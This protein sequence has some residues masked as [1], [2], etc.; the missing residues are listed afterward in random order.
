MKNGGG[1]ATYLATLNYGA[2]LHNQGGTILEK[3][4]LFLEAQMASDEMLES[5]S[6]RNALSLIQKELSMDLELLE[7]E[8]VDRKAS[9][10]ALINNIAAII[11]AGS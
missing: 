6:A 9:L 10:A 2:Y 5:Y 8:D 7:E 11:E 1:Y 4:V 3:G